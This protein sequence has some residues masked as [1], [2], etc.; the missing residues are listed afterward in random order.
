MKKHIIPPKVTLAI[1]L[2]VLPCSF[3]ATHWYVPASR[4]STGFDITSRPPVSVYRLSMSV[5]ISV[6]VPSTVVCNILQYKTNTDFGINF[7]MFNFILKHSSNAEP[8]VSL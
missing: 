5:V 7:A 8:K 3:V 6:S 2:R 4:A 1:S